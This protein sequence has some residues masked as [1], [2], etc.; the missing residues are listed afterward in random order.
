MEELVTAPERVH[1]CNS[2]FGIEVRVRGRHSD[3]LASSSYGF[4]NF[5]LRTRG[6]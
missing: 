3:L 1:Q 2:D 4:H 6:A 5:A